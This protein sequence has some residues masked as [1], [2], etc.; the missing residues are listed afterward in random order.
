MDWSQWIQ[1]AVN[2]LLASLAIIA[3][4]VERL[5]E[6]AEDEARANH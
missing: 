5:A 4:S 3:R 1:N 2:E 6:V